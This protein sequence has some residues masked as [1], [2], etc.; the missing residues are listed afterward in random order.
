MLLNNHFNR[1]EQR[2]GLMNQAPTQCESIL[3]F[4]KVGLINQTPT[5][6]SCPYRKFAQAKGFLL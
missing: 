2:V 3:T 6:K 5:N 4:K 1:G